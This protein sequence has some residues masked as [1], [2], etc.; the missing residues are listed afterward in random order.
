MAGIYIHIPFCRQ[1][2]YYCDFHFS[3]NLSIQTEICLAIG[4]ELELQKDYLGKDLIETIYFGGGTPSLLQDTDLDVIFNSIHKNFSVSA[5]PEITIEVNPDDITEEKLKSLKKFR[6][7][8]LSI[9]VQSFDDTILKFLNRFHNSAQAENSIRLARQIGF[10]NINIDLIYAIPARHLPLLQK[11]LDRLLS[12]SPEHISAYSLTVEEKTVFGKWYSAN[13][14]SPVPEEENA[15]QFELIMD[16]LSQ[17]GYDHY[18]ISNYAK[19]GFISGHNSSYWK[20][21]KYLGVGPSAHSFDG[22]SR[23][24]NVSNNHIYLKSLKSETVPATKET[25]AREDYINEY[26]MTS[27]RTSWGCRLDYLQSHYQ[28]DLIVHQQAYIQKF[29]QRGL[30]IL[31]ENILRLTRKGKMLADKICSDLFLI[32]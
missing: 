31:D 9:G 32:G 6:T 20:Q 4:R 5:D 24:A 23:Q 10:D 22:V 16:T 28:F 14:F 30:M 7:N 27:L 2:C 26:I 12:L 17:A 13:K 3:T 19:P 15:H 1:A 18:E 11:D 29:I 21:K 8:R 25:L